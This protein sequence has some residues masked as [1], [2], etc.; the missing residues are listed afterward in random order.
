MTDSVNI[1]GRLDALVTAL[2]AEGISAGLTAAEVNAP[3]VL[4]GLE[5][6]GPA[7]LAGP[8]AVVASLDLL[9]P[10][11][12]FPTVYTHLSTLIDALAEVGLDTV[13]SITNQAGQVIGWRATVPLD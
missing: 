4:V 9:V 2:R 11:V 5:S 7:L 3:G 10:D 8:P 1:G 12:G 6:I 13:A